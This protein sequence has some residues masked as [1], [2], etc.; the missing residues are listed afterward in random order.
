MLIGHASTFWNWVKT[1]FDPVFSESHTWLFFVVQP[2]SGKHGLPWPTMANCTL[3]FYQGFCFLAAL[4]EIVLALRGFS[5][6]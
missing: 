5:D 3:L 1:C 6:I 2:Y 4:Y